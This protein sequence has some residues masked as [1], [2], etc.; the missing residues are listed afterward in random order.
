MRYVMLY[1]DNLTARLPVLHCTWRFYRLLVL[2]CTWTV[3]HATSGVLYR[4]SLTH[5]QC[6][7]VQGLFNRL[8]VLCCAGAVWHATS[9]VYSDCLTCNQCCTHRWFERLPVLCHT[10]TFLQLDYQFCVVHGRFYWLLVLQW[11][12]MVWRNT[13]ESL[14]RVYHQ[15]WLFA[16]TIWE[17]GGILIDKTVNH[18]FCIMKISQL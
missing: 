8:P 3:W 5:Y 15:I 18:T 13:C 4:D 17:G 10:G 6:F 16:H 14:S 9:C 12:Q 2:C 7:V 11:A 1:R